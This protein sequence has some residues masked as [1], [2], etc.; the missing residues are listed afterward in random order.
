MAT[1]FRVARIADHFSDNFFSE[2]VH[3]LGKEILV[4]GESKYYEGLS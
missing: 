4:D 1:L 2:S 3:C